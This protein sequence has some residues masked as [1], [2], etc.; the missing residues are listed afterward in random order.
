MVTTDRTKAVEEL[1]LCID[2]ILILSNLDFKQKETGI[3]S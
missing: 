1:E 3:D 2:I